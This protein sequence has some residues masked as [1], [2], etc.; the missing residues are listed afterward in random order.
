LTRLRSDLKGHIQ[1]WWPPP[2]SAIPDAVKVPMGSGAF[3]EYLTFVKVDKKGKV[4]G[5]KRMHPE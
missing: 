2:A 1:L 3:M 5:K 4:N